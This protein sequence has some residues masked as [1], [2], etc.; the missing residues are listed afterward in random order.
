MKAINCFIVL[1]ISLSN[2]ILAQENNSLCDSKENYLSKSIPASTLTENNYN[3]ISINEIKMW[4]GNMGILS[5]DPVTGNGG[6]LWPGGENATLSAI[7]TEGILWGGKVNGELRVGGNNHR[8]NFKA[9]KILNSGLPDDPSLKKYRVFKIRKDWENLAPGDVRDALQKDLEEWPVED[10]APWK[11]NNGN[12]TYDVGEAEFCG[13]EVLWLVS[14]DLDTTGCN[15]TFGN[16]PIGIEVQ[17]CIYAFNQPGLENVI[18]RKIKLINKS[19]SAVEDMYTGYF[20][21]PD[22]GNSVDDFVGSHPILNMAYC[23]NG[24]NDDEGYY[25]TPPPAVGYYLLQGPKLQ[26]TSSDS[27]Y[28]NTA[29]HKGYKNL[30]LTSFMIYNCGASDYSCPTYGE[31]SAWYNG[32]QGKLKTGSP[33]IDPITGQVTTLVLNGDPSTK[34]GWYEGEGWPGGLKKGERY[35]LMGSGPFNFLPADT[36]EIVIATSIVKGTDN[37]NSVTVLKNSKISVQYFFNNVLTNTENENIIPDNFNLYQNYP[38]PFNPR[39]TIKYSIPIVETGHAP[40]V[41]ISLK[42]YDVLGREV[43]TLVNE[44][45]SAGNYQVTFDGSKLS[46]G[47]YFYKLKAGSFE[48]TRKLIL[49]K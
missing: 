11:D 18:F 25:L 10:G 38:N 14:N 29:W 45:Q 26:G 30:P 16:N 17:S 20:V 49:I 32:L 43:T 47:V 7:F 5:H 4:V 31:N 41:L 36:Q 42:V 12:R 8:G 28:F 15:F 37:I 33:V 40:S 3:Y 1:V 9:G 21:D 48:A 23:Y 35:F 39:T 19:S 22:L 46:S 6:F 44:E 24:D 34:T 27:A 13:D 2:F